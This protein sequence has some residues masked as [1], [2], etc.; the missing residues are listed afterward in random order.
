MAN[1]IILTLCVFL[2]VRIRDENSPTTTPF[3]HSPGLYFKNLGSSN[4]LTSEW[5]LVI[6]YNLTNYEIE[7]AAFHLCIAKFKSFC[8]ELEEV[9]PS[10]NHCEITSKLLEVHLG[11]IQKY[12]QALHSKSYSH[13]TRS[14]VDAGG[15]AMCYVKEHIM[16]I[17]T[18]E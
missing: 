11:E 8:I 16:H 15:Y 14:P 2:S 4:L 17:G 9:D 3:N 18:L 12:H 6:Y 7:L 5:N 10:S 1:L 13:K